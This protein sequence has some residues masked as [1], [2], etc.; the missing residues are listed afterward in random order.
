LS[1]PS[2]FLVS[3]LG[4][5]ADQGDQSGQCVACGCLTDTG[6]TLSQ[7]FPSMLGKSFTDWDKTVVRDSGG[8]VC[9]PCS[10]MTSAHPKKI[11]KLYKSR[12]RRCLVKHSGDILMIGTNRRLK[13]ILQNM[14]DEPF[15][16]M[17]SRRLASKFIHHIWHTKVSLDKRAFYYCNDTGNHLVR[18]AKTQDASS[19]NKTAMEQYLT[20][21]LENENTEP[22]QPLHPKSETY[23]Q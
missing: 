18:L 20:G 21:V 8:I 13:W 11:P 5:E 7:G 19:P 10:M 14:P 16:M 12:L 3:A 9:G 4:I 17:D 15:L 2:Q 23:N 6:L 1:S 22:E